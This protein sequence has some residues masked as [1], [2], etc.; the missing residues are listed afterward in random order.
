MKLDPH[1]QEGVFI[2]RPNRFSARVEVDGAQVMAHVP[3]SGRMRELFRKGARVFLTPRD[4]PG[5][6]TAFDLS[7]VQLG[8]ALVSS[9]ARLPSALVDEAIAC[10][11][12]EQF[13]SFTWRRREAT[14]SNSRLDMVLGNGG[15][16][17]IE[18]KSATLVE[19]GVALFPDAPTSRGA[20]H[21]EALMEA[22]EQGHRASVIFVVQREDARAFTPNFP[23]D[24]LFA[25]TLQKARTA[26]VEAYAYR[27]RVSTKEVVITDPLPVLLEDTP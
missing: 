5:R 14:F 22:I 19:G 8:D 27:C 9:D 2:D 16:C 4:G 6:K 17:Y 24:P 11:R 3:N 12:L 21:L 20:R 25:E 13:S 26:G 7:L 1:L 15:L 10:G 23:A 18:V